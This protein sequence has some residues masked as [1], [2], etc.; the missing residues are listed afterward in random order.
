M[1]TAATAWVREALALVERGRLVVVDYATSTAAMAG[2]P[3]RDWVRTYRGQ[4]RG[5]DPL[6]DPGQQDVTCEVAVD[7]LADAHPP[8]ADH[9]QADF[10]AGHGLDA[11]VEEGRRVWAE[12]AGVGDLAAVTARSRVREAEALTDPD[13]LGAFRVLEWVVGP[14]G[15]RG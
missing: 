8:T 4:G 12:R 2:R 10:L 14:T 6:E 9:S 5:S 13:G 3:W 11:L 7:Q 1:Q 15:R